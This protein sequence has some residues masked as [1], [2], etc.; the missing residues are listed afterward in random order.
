M[1]YFYLGEI[2]KICDR[3]PGDYWLCSRRQIIGHVNGKVIFVTGAV[4][5]DIA[6][7]LVTKNKKDWAEGKATKFNGYSKDRIEPFCIHFG[8]C[9]GCK[10]QMLS[11]EKQLLYK[12]Q[13][14]E[15][16]LKRIGKVPFQ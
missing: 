9:G 10:W 8:I 5:G 15:Q 4:P 12:Q 13:E 14:A 16:N 11:Y 3:K 1:K 2:K 6:D 7:M